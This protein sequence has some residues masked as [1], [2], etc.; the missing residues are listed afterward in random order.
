MFE[1]VVRGLTSSYG[2][3]GW[4]VANDSMFG[5]IAWLPRLTGDERTEAEDLAI[6]TLQA[7]DPR[8][9]L[10]LGEAGCTRAI[11]A[12]LNMATSA[13]TAP[14]VRLFAV[15]GL[16]QLDQGASRAAAIE[17]LRDSTIFRGDRREAIR[18]LAAHPDSDAETALEE[19]A[20]DA[21]PYVRTRAAWAL[22]EIRGPKG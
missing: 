18:V 15:R 2:H 7:G 5:D 13:S 8:A 20:A 1:A 21:D 4:K 12:L 16:I 9:A 19:A 11:P 14:N 10:T 6:A 17:I 3:L 22:E